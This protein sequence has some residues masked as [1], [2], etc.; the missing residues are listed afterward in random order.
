MIFRICHYPSDERNPGSHICIW[1]SDGLKFMLLLLRQLWQGEV[2]P[3]KTLLFRY[4]KWIHELKQ[5]SVSTLKFQP[6][7]STPKIQGERKVR[8]SRKKRE[9]FVSKSP[10]FV[11]WASDFDSCSATRQSLRKKRKSKVFISKYRISS[12][13]SWVI[14]Y[15]SPRACL[16]QIWSQSEH[17]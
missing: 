2:T 13:P 16:H 9:P 7:L 12:S 4:R 3:E 11:I 17:N 1:S 6:E 8:K 14:V 15:T 10:T 5:Q